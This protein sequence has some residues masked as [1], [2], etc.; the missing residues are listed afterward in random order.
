MIAK[1]IGRK[2]T[3]IFRN[4]L[5]S[6]WIYRSQ[7]DQEDY[8]ID[9]EIELTTTTGQ[10]TGFIFKAQIKGQ[11]SVNILSKGESITFSLPIKK[12]NYYMNQVNIPITL[13]VVDVTTEKVYWK[14][15]QNDV[16]L[17]KQMAEAIA[18]KQESISVYL[19]SENTLPEK[20][21]ELLIC[22]D[23]TLN[24]FNINSLKQLTANPIN[25]IIKNSSSIDL[26]EMLEG[27]KKAQ[28]AIYLESFER[29][30]KEER[31]DELFTI[32]KQVI[33]SQTEKVET[34]FCAGLYIEKV[35]IKKWNHKSEEY[36][37]L[38]SNLYLNMF[39]II[40]KEKVSESIKLLAILMIR[41]LKLKYAVASDI[42]YHF[43]SKIQ[44][45]DALTKSISD[46][47][48][49]QINLIAIRNVEKSIKLINRIINS[50][51]K[52]LLLDSLPRVCSKIVTFAN[53]LKMDG[54]NESS[55]YLYSWLEYCINLA[56]ELAIQAK[57]EGFF[58][59]ILV[60]KATFKINTPDAAKYLDESLKMAQGV[61]E[62]T[63]KAKLINYINEKITEINRLDED[64]PPDDELQ[65]FKERAEALGINVDDPNDENGIAIKQGFKD[66]NP[67]RVLKDCKN[68][69]VFY[70]NHKGIAA[71]MVSLASATHKYLY[72]TEKG[73]WMGG[74]T[75]DEIYESPIPGC[76]FKDSF[77]EGCKF[78]A[79][80]D[81]NWHWTSR[82][83]NEESQ[84]YL[85]V[86]AK[87]DHT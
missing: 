23:S 27:L 70:S 47:T 1:E 33:E 68:L 43:T 13:F 60:L 6:S 52:F 34:R 32:T 28:S 81:A 85:E 66:Y 45:I 4:T 76:G 7:E 16:E 84:K 48:K 71:R 35:Y 44:E 9:G 64:L 87:I 42:H 24:W 14:S 8:G 29:L 5:P 36:K 19:P 41:S 26:N 63:T 49:S 73:E 31:Y 77:C 39:Q 72:C 51:N 62:E 75:L 37:A 58:A 55:D 3:S 38:I 54:I 18:K 22:V 59:G 57:N 20:A 69:L 21:N 61:N 82:W 25:S 10:A 83:Q 67:E 11:E 46:I 30:F 56:I 17:R 53:R 79:P 15:L 78:K 80:R 65:F 74:W 40:R 86:F 2:A 12:L 50:D